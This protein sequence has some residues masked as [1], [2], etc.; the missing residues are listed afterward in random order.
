MAAKV[1][2]LRIGTTVRTD[3]L[4]VFT[5]MTGAAREWLRKGQLS[6]SS[7]RDLARQTGAR[8]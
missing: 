5:R 1:E 6:S 4:G 8:V 2:T 3:K 7:E